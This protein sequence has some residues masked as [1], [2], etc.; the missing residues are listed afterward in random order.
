MSGGK[1][2]LKNTETGLISEL[3]KNSRRSDR[4]LAK[5][6]NVSQPTVTRTMTKLER[7]GIIKEHTL[8][9]TLGSLELN[10]W[11]LLSASSHQKRSRTTLTMN[12]PTRRK[13][14]FRKIQMLSLPHLDGAKARKEC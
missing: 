6:L 11:R 2:K 10:P 7:E 12:G 13:S 14:F 9:L 4:Q 8:S 3:M 1:T 5:A